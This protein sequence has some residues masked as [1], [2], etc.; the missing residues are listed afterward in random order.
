[1]PFLPDLCMYFPLANPPSWYN[2]MSLKQSRHLAPPN[3]GRHPSTLPATAPSQSLRSQ[4]NA[5]LSSISVEYLLHV[6]QPVSCNIKLTDT[7][8]FKMAWERG[9]KEKEHKLKYTNLYATWQ[10]W[11]YWSWD[12][13]DSYNFTPPLHTSASLRHQPALLYLAWGL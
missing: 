7:T 5:L 11:K 8:Y 4:S 10:G 2:A 3:K 13:V 12:I 9:R 1:M 6:L